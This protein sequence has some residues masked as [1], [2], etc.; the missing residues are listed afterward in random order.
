[1]KLNKW[2]LATGMTDN[3]INDIKYIEGNPEIGI[4]YDY[5]KIR[6]L[7]KT[8]GCPKQFYN[9]CTAPIEKASWLVELSERSTGKTTGWLLWGLCMYVLY[10]TQC[11]YVRI[12]EEM[13]APK[14]TRGIY[15]VII[16][17]GYIEKLTKGEYNNIFYRAKR[18]FLCLTDKDGNVI[19]T[20][21][22]YCTFMASIYK[23]STL[24]SAHASPKGTLVILDEFI[25]ES[26]TYRG[27]VFLDFCN[28]CK[29]IFR[30]RLDG[31]IV[32][33]ANTLNKYSQWFHELH[34]FEAISDMQLS[35]NKLVT[36]RG[37][38]VIYIELIGAPVVLK[39]IKQR[40][41]KLFLGFDNPGLSSITGVSTWAIQSY[42]H[43]PPDV[44]DDGNNI[45][46][47]ILFRRIYIYHNNKLARLDIV[48]HQLLGICIYVHWATSTYDD[49]VILTLGEDLYDSRYIYGI[50]DDFQLGKFIRKMFATHKVYFAAND[51][52]SFVENFMIHCGCGRLLK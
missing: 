3:L 4:K 34:I 47:H 50:G 36:T 52:G 5:R 43:I 20:D 28:L 39:S 8:L 9:P 15:D 26:S 18:W 49:S 12:R 46:V 22:N 17:A 29:T 45:E 1:M 10:G 30:D 16:R 6:K 40:Y 19:K 11:H 27:N 7:Y 37:G 13:I 21:P 23:G 35:E 48:K 31:K 14:N 42:Q 41:N 51:V 44:D 33:L 25:D 24:K 32:L 2:R 38:S